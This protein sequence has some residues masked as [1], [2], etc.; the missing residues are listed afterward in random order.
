M[1]LDTLESYFYAIVDLSDNQ[2]MAIIA[3]LII[4]GILYK[5]L[6]SLGIFYNPSIEELMMKKSTLLY[7]NVQGNDTIFY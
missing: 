7:V 4:V 1:I 3:A 5:M 2:K 6:A